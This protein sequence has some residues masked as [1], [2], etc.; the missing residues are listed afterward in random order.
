V[1][2]LM[3]RTTLRCLS[4]WR[5]SGIGGVRSPSHAVH[6]GLCFPLQF[7]RMQ[8]TCNRN[9]CN[10]QHAEN[11]TAKGLPGGTFLEVPSQ[12]D[13]MR[14]CMMPCRRI[15]N[16]LDAR[17]WGAGVAAFTSRPCRSASLRMAASMSDKVGL[18]GWAG[19]CVGG[20]ERF[21]SRTRCAPFVT[22]SERSG[23]RRS[24]SRTPLNTCTQSFCRCLDLPCSVLSRLKWPRKLRDLPNRSPWLRFSV[25]ARL[26]RNVMMLSA[27]SPEHE[28]TR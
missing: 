9:V 23:F 10:I 1:Q 3:F 25:C 8:H 14:T 5:T 28:V 22:P 19:S 2:V 4:G 7:M 12:L 24:V 27:S 11:I 21:R 15:S 26:V 18:A 20:W 6:I 17:C 13:S 16:G